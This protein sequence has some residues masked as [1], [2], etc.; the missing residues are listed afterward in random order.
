[1][2]TIRTTGEASAVVTAPESPEGCSYKL[3]TAFSSYSLRGG[4]GSVTLVTNCAWDASSGAAWARL[5][6][7]D[8]NGS[9]AFDIAVDGNPEPSKRTATLTI[10][11]RFVTV[12]QAGAVSQA[13]FGSFD[14]PKDGASGITG[15]VGVTGWALD[16]IG[17]ARVRIFRD[18]V[19]GEPAGT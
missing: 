3:N 12:T 10:G 13:P 5:S 8:G 1:A 6:P 18:S 4:T 7:T 14:T 11:G 16:D 15:S 19:A 9:T 17:V 2:R